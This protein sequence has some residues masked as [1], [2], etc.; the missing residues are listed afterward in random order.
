[1]YGYLKENCLYTLKGFE[2]NIVCDLNLAQAI[3]SKIKQAHPNIDDET[4]MKYFETTLND[5]RNI[6]V[7]EERKVSRAKRLSL[8]PNFTRWNSYDVHHR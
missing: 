5:I 2:T 7:S 3:Y 4:S 8:H 6:K 1:M